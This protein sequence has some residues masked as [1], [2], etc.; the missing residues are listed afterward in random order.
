MIHASDR[1]LGAQKPARPPSS[2]AADAPTRGLLVRDRADPPLGPRLREEREQ[3]RR[4][5]LGLV[6]GDSGRFF[7]EEAPVLGT[8]ADDLADANA[9]EEAEVQRDILAADPPWWRWAR[10]R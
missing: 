1:H 9:P 4:A 7:D 3:L 6:L 8:R 10:A 5:P 2:L